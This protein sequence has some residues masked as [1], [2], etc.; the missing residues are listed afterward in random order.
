MSDTDFYYSPF[1]TRQLGKVLTEELSS[2][3][4]S[5]LIGAVA[6]VKRSGAQHLIE[7]LTEFTATGGRVRLAIGIDHQGTTIEGLDLLVAA[8]GSGGEIWVVHHTNA[9]TTFHPKTLLLENSTAALAL[10]GSG[11]LTE[12]GLF[13]NFEL[14]A[15]LRFDLSNAHDVASL[16]VLRDQ[17]EGYLRAAPI[18]LLLTPNLRTQLLERGDIV[19]EAQA[20]EALRREV[21]ERGPRHPSLFGSVPI[22]AAPRPASRQVTYPRTRRRPR[23][24]RAT[25][26]PPTVSGAP[27]LIPRGFVMVLQRTD[28]GVGQ[29]TA[30]TSRRSPEVFIPLAARDAS[31]EFWGWPD[32]FSEDGRRPGKFDRTAVLMRLGGSTIE[33]NMMTWPVK[34]DFRLRNESLRSSS[35]VGD[36]LRIERAEPGA[37]F[38]YYAEIVPSGTVL[39]PYYDAICTETVRNSTKR[40]GYYS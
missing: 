13:S 15:V 12:G 20:S 8:V 26:T 5:T 2:G 34:H 3:R 6:W 33:V 17:L 7:S 36:V 14:G 39:H 28:A 11:N 22:P 35:H 31:P 25:Q 24:S 10:I 16:S 9:A 32:L 19:S 29:T 38:E 27:E 40:W 21:R 37:P 1:G 23:S 30:G 4:W 18:S